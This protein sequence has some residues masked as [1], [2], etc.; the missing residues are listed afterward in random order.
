[1]TWQSSQ[2]ETAIDARERREGHHL[3]G[4]CTVLFIFSKIDFLVA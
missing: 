3:R 4:K 1:M 2:F